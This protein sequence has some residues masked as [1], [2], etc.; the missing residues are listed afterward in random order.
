MTQSV[1]KKSAV[2]K[3]SVL[4]KPLNMIWRVGQTVHVAGKTSLRIAQ[5]E[6]IS[7]SVLKQ[8]FEQLG[9]TYIKIGQFIAS[10]PSIFPRDYVEVFQ[11]CLD[12]TTPMSYDYIEEVLQN[13]LQKDGKTLNDIFASI[14][15]K[16]LA[17]A[18]I[19]QVHAAVLKNGDNVVL[20]VQKPNVAVIIDTDLTMLYGLTKVMDLL[21]PSLKFASISPIIDEIRLRMS[22]ETDFLQEANNIDDF[23]DFLTRSAN[24]K[25][26]VPKVYHALSTKKVL[27]M[28]RFFG[29]SMLDWLNGDRATADR[30]TMH[31]CQRP[32]KVMANTLNTWFDSLMMCNTFHADLHAGN[33]M[34]LADGRIGFLDF[35]IVGKLKPKAWQACVLMLDS[36]A[37]EDYHSMACHMIDMDMTNKADLAQVDDLANDLRTVVTTI[38]AEDR[39]FIGKTIDKTDPTKLKNHADEINQILL[40][41]IEVGKRH[42]IH[43]PRDFALLTKQL[44]YFDRFMKALTPDMTLFCDENIKMLKQKA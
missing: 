11:G 15:P 36:F 33:L 23:Q 32:D 37:K 40:Q 14:D 41:V 27:V 19:A 25:V 28:E 16:P 34:L 29:I 38:L 22:A 31:H 42:G 21:A 9:T 12:K 3:K 6:K 4:K 24:Q 44:L 7:P 17:S 30:K 26:A 35:G 43:F 1:F 5:G 10:T 2:F 13:E 18:S 20:K 39:L 8:S